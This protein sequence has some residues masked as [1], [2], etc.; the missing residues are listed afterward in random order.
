MTVYSYLCLFY[1]SSAQNHTYWI[2]IGALGF[3]GVWQRCQN[4]SGAANSNNTQAGNKLSNAL[5]LCRDRSHRGT[6]KWAG[7]LV[8]EKTGGRGF[9]VSRRVYRLR[10]G[11]YSQV[12]LLIRA[13]FTK[14][15]RSF[16]LPSCSFFFWTVESKQPGWV[17]G[18]CLYNGSKWRACVNA[19]GW[20]YNTLPSGRSP[21]MN[22]RVGN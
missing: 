12:D 18:E 1:T 11:L 14:R 16:Y 5:L 22:Q 15:E 4:T 2:S 13:P 20:Q 3:Y 7:S 19:K 17:R 21:Y 8:V 10:S 9:L 6:V